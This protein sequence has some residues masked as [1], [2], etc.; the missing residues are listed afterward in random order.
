MKRPFLILAAILSFAVI[1]PAAHGQT[2]T[3]VSYV[4]ATIA[5]ADAGTGS[6][7]YVTASGRPRVARV[8]GAARAR[9]A[10]LRPGDEVILTIEGPQDRPV[11]TG[12]KVSSVVPAAA[13]VDPAAVAQAPVMVGVPSRPSWPNPYS[14]LNPGLPFHPTRAERKPN[15]GTLNVMPAALMRPAAAPAPPIVAPAVITASAAPAVRDEGTAGLDATRARGARDFDAALARLDAEARAVDAVY[16]RYQASCPGAPS[17]GD[18]SR[19]WFGLAGG[20]AWS[21]ADPAC[22][23]LVEEIQQ[24]GAPIRA[25]M[26]AA[27]EAARK[28]WVL[29]GTLRDI[30][31]RHTM[32][33]SGY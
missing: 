15:A 9:L 31:R 7:G 8:A 33:W 21:G 1:V 32:D 13:A 27:Q 23:G 29:P 3:A 26:V 12:L 30:R 24:K 18:G 16:A 19:G 4:Q 25:G 17:G 14:R 6:L 10:S 20:A 22:A 11:V 2:G 5:E 28:A